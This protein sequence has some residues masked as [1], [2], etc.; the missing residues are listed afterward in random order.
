MGTIG[1]CTVVSLSQ[2]TVQAE[3]Q[4]HQPALPLFHCGSPQNNKGL[5]SNCI[6]N[7]VFINDC[8]VMYGLF[9]ARPDRT[10]D[11]C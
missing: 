3:Q 8:P 2:T 1:I 9:T 10:Y 5:L 11:T 6:Y 7:D 4:A